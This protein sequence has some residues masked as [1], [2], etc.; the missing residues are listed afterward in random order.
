MKQFI[1][2]YTSLYHYLDKQKAAYKNELGN[3]YFHIK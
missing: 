2:K 3:S 1:A